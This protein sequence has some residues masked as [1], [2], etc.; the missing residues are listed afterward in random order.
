MPNPWTQFAKTGGAVLSVLALL[1]LIPYVQYG[2]AQGWPGGVSYTGAILAS[3]AGG[4]HW[5][6]PASA[7]SGGVALVVSSHSRRKPRPWE[8]I[9]AATLLGAM[10]FALGGFIGP[11]LE[12]YAFQGLL[13]PNTQQHAEVAAVLQ[14]NDW[15]YLRELIAQEGGERGGVAQLVALVHSTVAFAI[16]PAIM[17][18]LGIAIGTG[19]GRFLGPSRRRA[20]WAMAAGTIALVYGAQAGAWRVAVT[21]EVWPVALVY[22]GFLTVPLVILLTLMWSGAGWS[23]TGENQ[24]PPPPEAI[25]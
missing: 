18:L 12:H 7:L 2:V 23:L 1:G 9:L 15:N 25:T 4:L 20:A 22:F 5:Y 19:S 13:D 16:L 21:A 14:P 3:W 11:Q 6:L 10:S 24:G 17:L 8:V